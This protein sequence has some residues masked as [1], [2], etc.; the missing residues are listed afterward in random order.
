MPSGSLSIAGIPEFRGSSAAA[1]YRKSSVTDPIRK[2]TLALTGDAKSDLLLDPITV[3]QLVNL[4]NHIDSPVENVRRCVLLH[5]GDDPLIFTEMMSLEF[6]ESGYMW[7]QR[8]RWIKYEQAVEGDFTRFS[9]PHIALLQVQALMQAKNCLKKG[10]VLLDVESSGFESIAHHVV[11][12]WISR[13]SMSVASSD[14]VLHALMAPKQHL[15]AVPGENYFEKQQ[16]HMRLVRDESGG[17]RYTETESA[18]ED[19]DEEMRH[20]SE[21]LHDVIKVCVDVPRSSSPTALQTF[22]MERD[23]LYSD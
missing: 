9:K 15:G 2:P 11:K 5:P 22:E 14:D 17:A 18:P 19:D 8:A 12:E 23:M 1:R 6:E 20:H 13:G 21:P 7:R 10:L 4:G 16:K 3:S